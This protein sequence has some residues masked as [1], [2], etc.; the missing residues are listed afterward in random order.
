MKEVSGALVAIVLVLSAVFIP[1][2]FRRHCGRTVSTVLRDRY[3]RCGDLWIC[4]TDA[5]ACALRH[6]FVKPTGD[7]PVSKPFRLFNQ[8]LAAFTMAFLQVVR[9]ALKSQNRICIDPHS[10]LHRRVAASA[11]YTDIFIP[12]EDQ[13]V[14]RMAVQLPEGSA[15]PRT[16]Q[17]A[18]GFL[19]KIQSLDGVQNVVTMMGF[20]TPRQ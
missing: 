1:V 11:D 14:V 7:K 4:C 20:D 5:H 15:F 19:K 17:V 9:A 12:K 13:G 16:E 18:E 10:R 3:H 8:G 2:A 6:S